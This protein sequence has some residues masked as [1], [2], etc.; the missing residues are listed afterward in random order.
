MVQLEEVIGKAQEQPLDGDI[1]YP[2][3]EETAEVHI[4][5]G[6]SKGSLRLDGA[7]DAQQTPLLRGNALFHNFP[8]A[9]EVFV[10]VEG[11]G[12]LLERFLAGTLADTFL[13][14][15][16]VPAVFTAVNGS[17]GEKV[18]LCFFF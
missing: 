4:L 10:D 9:K 14:T 3:R 17:F 11:F 15:G 5:L 7:V 16:T 6:H 18:S 2:S 13:L 8:L 1:V 12:S